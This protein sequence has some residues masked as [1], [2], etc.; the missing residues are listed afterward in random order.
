MNLKK[1][2]F[3]MMPYFQK[4]LLAAFAVSAM[5]YSALAT[6][7]CSDCKT[8]DAA[9]QAIQKLDASKKEDLIQGVDLIQ[10]SINS[11]SNFDEQKSKTAAKDTLFPKLLDFA[12]K[13]IP[14]DGESQLTGFVGEWVEKDKTLRKDFEGFLKALPTKSIQDK[15][16]KLRFEKRVEE[17]ACQV[18]EGMTPLDSAKADEGKKKNVSCVQQ[19]NFEECLKAK[20]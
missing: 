15:C 17:Q 18:R 5:N 7:A 8:L 20:K 10:N 11:F 16:L 4:A 6:K 13:A 19:F 9:I 3:R 1:T 14:F 2:N 12:M